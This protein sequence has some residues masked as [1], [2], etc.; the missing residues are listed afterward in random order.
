M[1][2]VVLAHDD[3][4][5]RMVAIKR[6]H[7]LAPTPERRERFRREARIVARLDHPAIVQ[8]HDVLHQGDHDYLIMEYVEGQT[9]R[10]RCAA[11]PMTVSEV[12]GIAH[13]IAL[14]M[15]AAHDRG[16]IHRDLKAENVLITQA[17]RAK[18][19]DFG[20][21]KLEGD[22]T[23]TADG[24]V[25]G[26]FRAMSPE[27]ALGRTIDH[28]SDL[29]SFGILLY[30]ALSGES[31]FR[32]DSSFLT[33]QRLVRDDPR[34]ITELV[35]S[36]P[37]SLASLV[38]QLLAKE[39]LLRPRD[40][41]EVADALSELA[42]QVGD[43]SCRT[44]LSLDGLP[45]PSE[46][47]QST[48][49][50]VATAGSLTDAGEPPPPPAPASVRAAPRRRWWAAGLGVA[51]LGALGLGYALRD[52]GC[53]RAAPHLS[54]RVAAAPPSTSTRALPST[55]I[56]RVAVLA[57]DGPGAEGRPDVALLADSV[58][59][60]VEA[61]VRARAGLDLIP[62]SDIENYVEGARAT[63]HRPSQRATQAAV[64]AD[65]V[66]A[67]HLA[68]QP[69]SCR[70]TLER[71]PSAP[72]SPPP[73]SFQ[74]A[75]DSAR[76]PGETVTVHLSRLYPDH[77]VLDAATAGSIDPQDHERYV[78]LVHDYWAGGS[79]QPTEELLAE[80]ERMRGRSPRSIDVL[81][82][83]AEVLRHRYVQTEDRAQARRALALLQ[84]A[85]ALFPNTYD[86]LSARF[87]ILLAARSLDEA[88][89][90]L[91]RLATLDPD[92][93]VTHL[94]RAKL[95]ERR[96]EIERGRGK[97]EQARGEIEQARGE[98]D[99]A[100]L[101]DSSSWRVLYYRALVSKQL[102]D[103]TATRAAINQLLAHSPGNYGGLSLLAREELDA[104]RLACAAQIYTQ[105]VARKQLYQECADLGYTLNQLGQYREAARSFRC[106]LDARPTDPTAL[107]GLAESLLITGDTDEAS[108][109]L[110]TLREIFARKRLGSPGN[111]L[112]GADL[113]VE[114]QT[115]A[116]L[117]RNAPDLA[118][119]ARA[120]VAALLTRG[121]SL[122][123][124]YTAALV[125][126]VL[127]DRD[128]AAEYVTKYLE[129]RGNPAY[130]GYPWFDDLRRD[131]VL[132]P[133]LAVPPSARSCDTPTP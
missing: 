69:D 104:D 26:T 54:I 98:I 128:L 39:P 114:A 83:E 51:A 58:R 72:G 36:L 84:D 106:A 24:V 16:V 22:D 29:F 105:L 6:L 112:E 13:Q 46:D 111:A 23:V 32:A 65:E 129:D 52:G 118:A 43:T 10:A 93:S 77:P 82:F 38:H 133:R 99:A 75:T 92:S 48:Q 1:G 79:A 14:G 123:A 100:A 110:R 107:L 30:E 49:G 120:R 73:E 4:L 70:V 45:P 127:G 9:L 115:L 103:P 95:H 25:I 96:G 35:P 76:R 59:N 119:E 109:R 57:P 66:I 116:Y 131:P 87:D 67:T 56:V 34:P 18:L 17:D 85:E 68:C 31:P 33:V 47:T 53:S 71:A 12:L 37:T 88:G 124:L 78:Q 97:I 64:G 81:L 21:A 27:Q 121:A 62:R 113:L 101:R 63:G 86:I 44:G 7:D 11:G 125:Y 89:T 61:S 5:D 19:T 102:G 15:A 42:S 28:R 8:I 90:V 130:L 41:H 50:S 117:G 74:L 20:I 132:R 94:Q 55:S 91:D 122:D 2:E 126:A 80:V 3:R 108:A 60:A 40:F